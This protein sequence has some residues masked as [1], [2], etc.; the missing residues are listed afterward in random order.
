MGIGNEHDKKWFKACTTPE[1]LPFEEVEYKLISNSP[2][3][4]SNK[5]VQQ[6]TKKK[7]KK[8]KKRWI[9]EQSHY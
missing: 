5:P 2:P 4:T 6:S 3:A 9:P 1:S 7:K 8:K